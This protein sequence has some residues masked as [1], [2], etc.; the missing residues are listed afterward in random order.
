MKINQY[1]ALGFSCYGTLMDRQRGVL[2][3]DVPGAMQYLSKFY[4]LVVL[5]PADADSSEALTAQLPVAFDAQVT[6]HHEDRRAA[7]RD[8]LQAVGLRREE[9]LPVRS[10]DVD[11]PWGDLVDFPICTLRRD[12]PRPWRRP[13]PLGKGGRC[14]YAS[15][16]DLVLAHQDAL[17][18]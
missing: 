16:A 13:E 17:R 3:E 15:L 9:L 1:R 10:T 7:L 6:Y 5:L 14:E 18:G 8:T 2:Y 11:D 4:R 12:P